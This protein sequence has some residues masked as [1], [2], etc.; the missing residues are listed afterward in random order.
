MEQFSVA[1]P[2]DFFATRFNVP[3]RVYSKQSGW[4]EL[5]RDSWGAEILTVFRVVDRVPDSDPSQVFLTENEELQV[6]PPYLVPG[7]KWHYDILSFF[8]YKNTAWPPVRWFMAVDERG[9]VPALPGGGRAFWIIDN[10]DPAQ[11]LVAS[12]SFFYVPLLALTFLHCKN[13][14]VIKPP[15]PSKK[16]LPRKRKFETRYHRL[17]IEAIGQKR[18]GE[19]GSRKTGIEQGLHIVRGHFREYGEEFGKG[20]L[21]GKYSGRYWVAAHM[22]GSLESGVVTKDYEIEAPKENYS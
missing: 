15:P 3:Q 5:P 8:A 20:K 21:F 13:V 4:A 16:R 18:E 19:V 1:P 22:S 11:V 17:K 9:I 14:E 7:A 6:G 10:L 12:I 2:F